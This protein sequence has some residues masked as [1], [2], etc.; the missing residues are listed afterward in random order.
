[1]V[2]VQEDPNGD[3][4]VIYYLRKGLSSLE[5]QYSHVEK[6][7]LAVV[8]VVHRFHHYIFLRTTIVSTDSNP[9]YH[10][11]TRQVLGRKYSKCIVMLQEFDL[12]FSKSKAKK[13]LVFSELTCDL[14]HAD[15]DIEPRN[16]L[17][18]ESLFLIITYDPW[19]G[20]I[21]LYL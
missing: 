2:L 13:Y 3:E 4:H 8:I 15:E 10:I 19:Y 9:M 11:L 5:L 12:K 18:N 17:P 21:I 7:A 14:P 6:L 20:D 1:M 16:Y